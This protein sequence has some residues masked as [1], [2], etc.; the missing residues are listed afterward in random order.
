M[1]TLAPLPHDAVGQVLHLQLGPGQDQY[2]AAITDMTRETTP[3]VEFHMIRSAVDAVGFFK[4]DLD[5]AATHDFATPG[6][7]GLRGFLIG[8]Q[9][10]G[11]GYGR[12]ALHALPD[13]LAETYPGVRQI[14][15]TVNCV[16][17][18]AYRSYLRGG[19][20]DDGALYLGG[21]SG[22]QHILTLALP[23]L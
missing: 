8:A 23:R 18:I 5:F 17:S 19:W 1:I 7:V 16:N 9:F 6:T 3:M 12:A 21:R 20:R 13:Y 14:M 15:L 22:P 10:Q 4:I 11:M 2:V